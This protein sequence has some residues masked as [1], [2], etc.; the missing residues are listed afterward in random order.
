MRKH[1]NLSLHHID[2]P[3]KAKRFKD[4]NAD[5]QSFIDVLVVGAQTINIENIES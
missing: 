3:T 5:I 4:F 2:E 1:Q